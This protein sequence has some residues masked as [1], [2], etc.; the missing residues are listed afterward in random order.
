M[1][2]LPTLVEPELSLRYSEDFSTLSEQ[3]LVLVPVHL[4]VSVSAVADAVPSAA[5]VPE[6]QSPQLKAP[7]PQLKAPTPPGPPPLCLPLW[8]RVLRLKQLT[9][10]VPPAPLPLG[11]A[12]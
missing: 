4:S 11:L 1:S 9:A 10:P 5:V 2:E 3:K 6:S 8:L 12:L 7:T